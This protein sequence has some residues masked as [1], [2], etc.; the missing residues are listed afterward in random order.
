[1]CSVRCEMYISNKFQD[2]AGPGLPLRITAQCHTAM[3]GLPGLEL[4]NVMASRVLPMAVLPLSLHA[5]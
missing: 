3:S 4:G 5:A 2:G 1:M